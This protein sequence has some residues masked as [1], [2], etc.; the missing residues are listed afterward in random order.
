MLSYWPQYFVIY[1][2]A[3][4]NAYEREMCTSSLPDENSLAQHTLGPRAF[5]VAGSSLCN[6]VPDS[7]RDPDLSRDNFRRLLKMHLFTL[8]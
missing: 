5:S 3:G 7:L 2:P 4:S 8:Y 1:L 6:C